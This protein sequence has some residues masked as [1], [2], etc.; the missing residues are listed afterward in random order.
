MTRPEPLDRR[1]GRSRRVPAAR[2]LRLLPIAVIAV[3]SL[4][5][6]A[7][8]DGGGGAAGGSDELRTVVIWDR[9]GSQADAKKV[10]FDAWNKAKG[11]ELGI[12]VRY[13]PQAADKYEEIVRVAFQTQRGPDIFHTPSSQLGGFVGGGWVMPLDEVVD[14]S[15]LEAAKPYLGEDS[16]LV[17]G[18]KPYAIPT[19]LAV[20]RL[21][22]NT[23]LFKA[24]GLD[25]EDPPATFSELVEAS[26]KI[27]EHQQGEAYGMALR[28]TWVGFRQW[29]VDLM[30]MASEPDLTNGMFNRATGKYEMTKY[31]DV[32]TA[33]RQMVVDKS[34]Y[35]G[36]ATLDSDVATAAFANGET[37][38]MINSGFI[39]APLKELKS[40]VEITAAPLPVADGSE[41]VRMPMNAGYP[42]GI[43]AMT[44]EPEAAATVLEDL[45]SDDVQNALAESDVP[46]VSP[47][48]WDSPAMKEKTDLQLFRPAELDQ[49]WPKNPNAVVPIEGK[50][51]DQ[52]VVDLVVNSDL[53]IDSTLKDLQDR[54][55]K[56]YQQAVDNGELDPKEF[57][58]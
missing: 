54:Y 53:P 36:T 45:V 44:K 48:V 35:P 25:P 10:Y 7:C 47:A 40:D 34:V 31:A 16:E 12:K 26:K 13:E 28:T 29:D 43:S 8:G 30:V 6:T 22:I 19:T 9:A 57:T 2:L 55:N 15:V 51:V 37:A 23:E 52:T 41:L 49:Q 21:V 33:L 46:P 18:G 39:V 1:A 58:R 14:Q 4:V 38:M 42:Y 32:V 11:A 20:N 5:L 50:D 3:L 27:A 24:A 56:A 17:W